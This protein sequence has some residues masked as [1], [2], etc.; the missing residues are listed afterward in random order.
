MYIFLYVVCVC[1]VTLGLGSLEIH[2][3]SLMFAQVSIAAITW[4]GGWC[5]Q[6]EV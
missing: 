1:I 2:I 5:D 4:Q 3:I 6:N